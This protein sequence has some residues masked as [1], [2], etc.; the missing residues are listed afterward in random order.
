MN[1]P[2]PQ[3]QTLE[4]YAGIGVVLLVATLVGHVLKVAVARGER[5]EVIDNLNARIRSWWVIVAVTGCAFLLGRTGVTLLFALLGALALREFV[6]VTSARVHPSC[7]IG[8]GL[9]LVLCIAHAPALLV[10]DVSGY[11]GRAVMLI[12]FLV[13]VAQASDVL[14]YVWGKL[15]GR[16]Q[17]APSWSPAKTW[18]GAIGGVASAT[19]LGTALWWITP[20]APWQAGAM[21]LAITVMGC[22][23]GIALSAVKRA[24]GA[25]DW[26]DLIDGHGG[27]LDRLDSIAFAAPVFFYLTRLGWT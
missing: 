27:V 19:L 17:L 22:A 11:E 21:A 5:H 25:K 9:L 2:T 26:G 20:F 16:R 14:Q 8:A 15:A 7:A 13:V 18:E 23:G 1:V 10:L 24:C 12:V 4:L 6:T 3:R